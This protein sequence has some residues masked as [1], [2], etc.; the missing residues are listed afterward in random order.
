MDMDY[1]PYNWESDEIKS[2]IY[3]KIMNEMDII[4]G[5]DLRI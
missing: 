1:R 2:N 3:K 5:N 4:I